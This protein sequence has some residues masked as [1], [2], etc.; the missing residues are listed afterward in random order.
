MLNEITRAKNITW[1]HIVV[2]PCETFH[3]WKGKP[4]YTQRYCQVMKYHEP[5]LA[6][7]K[8]NNQAFHIDTKGLPVYSNRFLETFGVYEALAAVRNE[9]GWFH[10]TLQGKAA[11][12]AR[13]D[14]CGNFQ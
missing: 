2:S 14:W 5:A 10:I 6:P 12:L 3:L 1:K 13:Y 4:L 11:Y 9:E 7:V 8:E